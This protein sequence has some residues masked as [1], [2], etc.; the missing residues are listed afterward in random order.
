[1]GL[2]LV[3]LMNFGVVVVNN[4]DC[5]VVYEFKQLSP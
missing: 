1:M 4:E 5:G 3:E 2:D